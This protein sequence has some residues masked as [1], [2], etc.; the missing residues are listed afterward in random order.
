MTG[1]AMMPPKMKE[2]PMTTQVSF[3]TPKQADVDRF[4]AQAHKMRS[5]FMSHLF[6]SGFA[7]L[8]DVFPKGRGVGQPSA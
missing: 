7:R 2:E 3:E 1:A 4:I 6:K 5:D 8:R